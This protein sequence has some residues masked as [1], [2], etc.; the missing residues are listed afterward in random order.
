MKVS[1]VM[2]TYNKA[3]YLDLTLSGFIN[4]KYK[5][6]EIIIIN[7]G[8]K[9]TTESIVNKYIRTLNIIYIFQENN[10]RAAARNNGLAKVSGDI[11]LFCDDDR[12]PD[13]N[14]INEHVFILNKN[15][16]VVTIGNKREIY[17]ILRRDASYKPSFIMELIKKNIALMDDDF[18]GDIKLFTSDDIQNDM[19]MVIQKFLSMEPPDNFGIV[20]KSFGSDLT[21]FCF[22]WAI[23][24]TA[25][26]GLRKEN[27][28]NIRFDENYREWGMEDT[29]FAYELYRNNCSF[30]MA[31]QAVNY[32]Q[33]HNKDNNYMKSLKKN[34]CYFNDKYDNIETVLF[35]LLLSSNISFIEINQMYKEIVKNPKNKI[36]NNYI[37]LIRLFMLSNTYINIAYLS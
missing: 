37:E 22:G 35:A 5:N 13:E 21:G 16:N 3:N 2:P 6:F 4:Q 18:Y 1:I 15:K 26:L 31:T 9:D 29:D 10:G 25:N 24:T 30:Y 34:L 32:H 33:F 12:I 14:F 17:S 19:N 36:Y 23:A 7:D 20:N 11:I 28:G 8:S 27:L